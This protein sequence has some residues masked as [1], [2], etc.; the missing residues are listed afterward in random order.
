MTKIDLPFHT[1][2]AEG[3]G[4]ALMDEHITTKNHPFVEYLQKRASGKAIVYRLGTMQESL[5]LCP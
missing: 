2:G 1:I 3:V 4:Q 5:P